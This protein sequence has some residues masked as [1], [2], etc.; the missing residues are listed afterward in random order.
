ML[1][2]QECGTAKD[3]DGNVAM[4][5]KK[6]EVV[7]GRGNVFRDLRHRNADADQF[8]ANLAAEIQEAVGKNTYCF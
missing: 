1:R 4:K 6:L 2:R 5:S 3:I 8:K 7:K